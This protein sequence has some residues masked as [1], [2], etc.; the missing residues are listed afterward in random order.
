M[1]NGVNTTSNTLIGSP[2]GY[3]DDCKP[4]LAGHY[5]LNATITPKP[6][7]KGFFTKP[8]Q[9]VCKIC[10]PGRYCSND[11]TTET[12]MNT[13]MQCP[14]GKYCKGGLKDVSEATDC[15]KAHYCPLGEF[16]GEG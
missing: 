11:T 13:T 6:C 1:P 10:L 8:G 3:Q 14:K 16:E 5:C 12:A 2:A 15:N 4:C 9:S 7:G